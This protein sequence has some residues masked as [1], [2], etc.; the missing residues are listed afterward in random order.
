MFLM[1]LVVLVEAADSMSRLKMHGNQK[2]TRNA[3]V[4]LFG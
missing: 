3:R 1:A 4:R 2:Q